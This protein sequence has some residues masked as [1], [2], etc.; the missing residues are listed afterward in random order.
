MSS[1]QMGSTFSG[2]A[3]TPVADQ[4]VDHALGTLHSPVPSVAAV[5]EPTSRE[6][7]DVMGMF[8]TGIAVA[9]ARC[10]DFGHGMTANSLTSVSL[11]PLLA[12]ICVERDALMRKAIEQAG[13]FAVSVLASDQE[14]LSRYFSDA[15]RPM[16]M[17]QFVPVAW[18]PGPLTGAPLLDD[19]LAF[20]ELQVEQVHDGGDH[21][22]FL[23]RVCGVAQG[24]RVDPLLYF[25][26]GY[27]RLHDGGGFGTQL[28]A[29]Q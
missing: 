7:R 10:G 2:A 27:H 19:A 20:I 18:R 13:T 1:S 8:A 22:I 12:L 5:T 15:S 24:R 26:G 11:D 3:G 29:A 6:Y 25:R 21:L 14:Y 17:A 28:D 16:G 9:T 23:A 4:T